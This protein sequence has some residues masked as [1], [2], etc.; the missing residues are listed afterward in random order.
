MKTTTKLT[1]VAV[2][3]FVEGFPFG[4]LNDALPLFFRFHGVRLADIGLLSLVGL[5]WTL[6]F[7][8]APAVDLWGRRR[9]WVV[10]CQLLITLGLLTLPALDPSRVGGVAWATLLALAVCS[11]TQDI[12]IDAYTIELLDE[13]EMGPA[14]GIRVTAYRVALICA[15]GLFV[16]L[17][18]LIGW[19]AAFGAAAIVVATSCLLS[20]RMPHAAPQPVGGAAPGASA[21]ERAVWTPLEQFFGHPGFFAV[22]LF[23]LTFKL[24]DMSLGP[25]VRPFWVDRHF[26]PLEIGAVPGTLGV[27]ATIFG[28]LLGG[29]LTA[30]WGIFRALWVLGIA[31]AASNLVYAAAAAL[32]PSTP[33]MY[34]SSIVESFCGGLGTAPFLAFL[35]SICDKAHA[36]TQYALLSAL[37]GLTR[38]VAGTFSGWATEG[39]GYAAYFTLTFFLA[40]PALLLLPRVQRWTVTRGG[41]DR[42]D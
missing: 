37:F 19:P 23:V 4:I 29:S 15:G 13:A 21:L 18:G 14:N 27:I 3:Y 34:A 38:V 32:P 20:C 12:A 16:A 26:T 9:T 31:Q 24:G 6:K 40:W 11:A 39:F 1:W 42:R 2:L 17:A 28:A 25:M 5:P 7:L 22:M 30:R 41:G 10:G 35:M 33:L 36:A 8:W